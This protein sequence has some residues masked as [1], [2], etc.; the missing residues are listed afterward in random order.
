MTS[1][2]ATSSSSGSKLEGKDG[3]GDGMGQ[4]LG[5]CCVAESDV[6]GGEQRADGV[7]V[8]TPIPGDDR[9]NGGGWFYG[10]GLCPE[11]SSDELIGSWT[12][13]GEDWKLVGNKSG[14]TR[15]GFAVLLK[16][17]EIKARFPRSAEEVPPRAVAYVAEQVKVDPD[18]FAEYH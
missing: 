4:S 2:S 1:G 16:F 12:L 18:A 17:F 10:Y 8:H 3:A 5:T 13:V 14:V 15:L 11:W 6:A 7:E 9:K